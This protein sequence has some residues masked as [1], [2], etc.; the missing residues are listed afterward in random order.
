MNTQHLL[1]GD[2]R[3][4]GCFKSD[5]L[6]RRNERQRR[7][8]SEEEALWAY[9]YTN[10]K[11]AARTRELNWSLSPAEHRRIASQSCFY[12]DSNEKCRGGLD[13]VFVRRGGWLSGHAIRYTGLDRLDN[14]LG[15]ESRNVVAACSQCNILKNG[16]TPAMAKKLVT[17][18]ENRGL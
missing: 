9:L 12:Q 4:C 10:K 13:E 6:Q 11:A 15:Y 7:Y 3:S 14:R 18:L 8:G 16:I 5:M 17:V 1:R 2:V